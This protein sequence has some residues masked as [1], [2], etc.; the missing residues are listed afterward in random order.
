M[1]TLQKEAHVDHAPSEGEVTLVAAS[2]ALEDAVAPVVAAAGLDQAAV[3]AAAE[4][5]GRGT[6]PV[7]W[8]ASVEGVPPAGAVLVG[9]HDATVWARAAA[10]PSHRAVVLPQGAAWLTH[11]L[12][13]AARTAPAR[14]VVVS[15]LGELSCPDRVSMLVAKAAS[16]ARLS[17][18]LV[19]AH[20]TG[21]IAAAVA[22]AGAAT[23]GR[24][25]SGRPSPGRPS[26]GWAEAWD[27]VR[28][29]SSGSLLATLPELAGVPVLTGGARTVDAV[30]MGLVVAALRLECDLVVLCL[31]AEGPGDPWETPEILRSFG[32][33]EERVMAVGGEPWPARRP[34]GTNR[35]GPSVVTVR[36]G[37][38]AP[39][40]PDAAAALGGSWAGTVDVR[41][42]RIARSTRRL[43]MR[44]WVPR[45]TDG[46]PLGVAP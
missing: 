26:S 23:T 24:P 27:S 7:L 21:S 16:M 33:D 32:G 5:A 13:G 12:S 28:D 42:L 45:L 14:V 6:G 30:K 37:R 34:Q 39:D 31:G 36:S 17:A 46:S 11:H 4:A 8:D 1:W 20:G 38:R 35:G 9:L 43:M 44:R 29:G 41:T 3:V 40:G 15:G 2:P 22:G 19:D 10:L 18:V 25:T